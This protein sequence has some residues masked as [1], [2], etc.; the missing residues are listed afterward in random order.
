MTSAS[1]ISPTNRIRARRTAWF[2]ALLPIIAGLWWI[3]WNR[4]APLPAGVT[5][6]DFDIASRRFRT[7]YNRSPGTIDI[8]SI[9]G[10]LAVAEER[11][12]AA[13]AC[14]QQIPGDHPRYGPS[15]RLQEAQVRL[16]LNQAV[17][18]ERNFRDYIRLKNVDQAESVALARKWLMYILSVELRFEDRERELAVIHAT[19]TPD[20]GDSKQFFFPNLLIWNSATGRQRLA[21]FIEVDPA[22]LNL[23]LAKGRYLT[24]AGQ[25]DD[26]NVLLEELYRQHPENPSCAAAL[27]ECLFEKNDWKQFGEIARQLP[28]QRREEPW[29]LVRMRGEFALFEKRWDEAIRD[30]LHLAEL[31][32]ANPWTSMGLAKAYGMQNRPAERDR[33]LARALVLSRIRVSL[34]N[35]REDNV[36]AVRNLANECRQIELLQAAEA[37]DRH[38]QR[39]VQSGRGTPDTAGQTARPGLGE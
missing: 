1:A 26:A 29:L 34:S 9:A 35:V 4:P 6:R 13:A 12:A 37:F 18:A 14:F 31:E 3:W 22:D 39:I 2:L 28:S 27:L 11:F 7:L 24:G 16:R 32:P 17:A 15:A 23:R 25:L 19:G 8:L 20:L 21:D 5:Q 38:V 36:A 10:E 33:A 30:F